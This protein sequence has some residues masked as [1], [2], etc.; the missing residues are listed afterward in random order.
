[1]LESS[2][3]NSFIPCNPGPSPDEICIGYIRYPQ[4]HEQNLSSK[5]LVGYDGDFNDEVCRSPDGWARWMSRPSGRVTGSLLAIIRKRG[6][7][8]YFFGPIHT[9]TVINHIQ[10]LTVINWESSMNRVSRKLREWQSAALHGR[11][12]C[13]VAKLSLIRAN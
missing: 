1:M 2:K 6:L 11:N 4:I 9:T 10:T 12:C 8:W 7:R 3:V 13:T 5:E